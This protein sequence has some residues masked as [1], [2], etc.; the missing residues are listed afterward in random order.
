MV[1]L[2][3]HQQM[4]ESDVED[5]KGPQGRS[6]NLTPRLHSKVTGFQMLLPEVTWDGSILSFCHSGSFK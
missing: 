4:Y 5:Q 6:Q 3:K 1:A 2:G